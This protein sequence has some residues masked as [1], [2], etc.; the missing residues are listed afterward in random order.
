MKQQ[1]VSLPRPWV[2]V[3]G[4]CSISASLFSKNVTHNLFTDMRALVSYVYSVGLVH[5][6]ER[7]IQLPKTRL[8]MSLNLSYC[9]C[10]IATTRK[11]CPIWSVA[12][13]D[14][15]YHMSYLQSFLKKFLCALCPLL[16]I[17]ISWLQCMSTNVAFWL[18]ILRVK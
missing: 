18:I 11:F 17:L 6:L 14:V 8:A 3:Y 10:I 13:S 12:I 16:K 1:I 15:A 2:R 9:I 7:N 5:I 4:V